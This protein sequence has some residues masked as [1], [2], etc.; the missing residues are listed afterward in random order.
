MPSVA[1][2][3]TRNDDPSEGEWTSMVGQKGVAY[4]SVTIAMGSSHLCLITNSS[5]VECSGENTDL[6]LGHDCD[7][8]NSWSCTSLMPIN[9]S[10]EYVA[11]SV[12]AGDG[13]SCAIM[14][15]GS[16]YCWGREWSGSNL[17]YHPIPVMIELENHTTAIVASRYY[18]CAIT[19]SDEHHS[20]NGQ[21]ICWRG[22]GGPGSNI[23]KWNI[24]LGYG[25]VA[26]SGSPDTDT[27][28]AIAADGS[29]G[30]WTID[31]NPNFPIFYDIVP[32]MIGGL[33]SGRAHGQNADSDHLINFRAFSISQGDGVACA[34]GQTN[35]TTPL[36]TF[37]N[38]YNG[39]TGI[40]FLCWGT[41]GN[42]V[43]VTYTLNNP[44]LLG[45]YDLYSLIPGSEDGPVMTIV[46][47]SQLNSG[48]TP[49]Q[50]CLFIQGHYYYSSPQMIEYCDPHPTNYPGSQGLAVMGGEI[51]PNGDRCFILSD[52]TLSCNYFRTPSGSTY[53]STFQEGNS[54][55]NFS[56]G[57]RDFDNDSIWNVLDAFP[58]DPSEWDDTDF[59]GI[60]NNQDVDD[61]GDGIDDNTD[62]FP[63]DST[64]WVDVDGD[65]IGD[66]SDLDN[67]NDG[68]PDSIDFFPLD[69]SEWNDF[70]L[71]GIGDNSDSDDDNDGFLDTED[72]F[73]F[74]SSEWLDTDE[75]GIGNND[76][77]DDD[78]DNRDDEFDAFPLHHCAVKDTDSDGF[79]DFLSGL[80]SLE[81]DD[82]DD[83]DSIPDSE[84]RCPSGT[85]ETMLI[86]WISEKTTDFDGDGC[87]DI[88]EDPDDDG[89]GVDDYGDL[90]PFDS[91]DWYDF[92][93][94]GIGNNADN[95]DDNDGVE[96]T[97]DVWPY[98]LCFDTDTD[99][100][101]LPDEINDGCELLLQGD[102]YYYF[103]GNEYYSENILDGDDDNDGILDNLDAFPLDANRYLPESKDNDNYNNL[104]IPILLVVI[105]VLLIVIVISIRGNRKKNISSESEPK[106]SADINNLIESY[107]KQM[108]ASGYDENAA[109]QYAEQFYSSHSDNSK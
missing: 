22:A 13:H 55:H 76:D 104:M 4:D 48:G 88:D 73:Q 89:D 95:D 31:E 25:A 39:P 33:G 16:V 107:V 108:V 57:G 65:G 81:E 54:A 82:D 11:T 84:D 32:T 91:T 83:N 15:D 75:D 98:E 17:Y 100:D 90:F 85:L 77:S 86:G 58:H 51:R 52:Y 21:I 5:L 28:C 49:S 19:N 92:D 60:G 45:Y 105:S 79:P 67:D 69:S 56:V 9:L 43:T 72:A 10:I 38:Q 24:D 70:D 7:G 68:H 47:G 109:R 66:N 18:T 61:D 87:R 29:I 78:G 6:Q 34:L 62:I 35:S 106:E 2:N 103:S 71:D 23:D 93:G 99:Q 101:G 26:I 3:S 74:D 63:Y 30:C 37:E 97:T 20:N 41:F 59:D 36:V 53:S 40:Q 96:D 14:I 94:D 12:T 42:S 64:E 50:T 46:G 1:E 44:R 8:E 102:E 27:F 80:C